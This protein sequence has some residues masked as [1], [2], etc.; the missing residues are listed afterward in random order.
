MQRM[1]TQPRASTPFVPPVSFHAQHSPIGAFLSFT[2]GLVGKRGGLAAQLGRPADQDIFVGIH[3]P[4]DPDVPLVCFPF[5]EGATDDPQRNFVAGPAPTSPVDRPDVVSFAAGQY[6]RDYRYA[7]D[8]FTAGD[9][10]W[11]IYTPFDPIPD[12]ETADP[13]HLAQVLLPAVRMELTLD[14]RR[15]LAARTIFFALRFQQTGLRPITAGLGPGR[16]GFAVRRE[17][18]F[19]AQALGPD[20]EPLQDALRPF[21]R[22]TVIDALTDRDN[23]VHRLGN[24]AGVALTVPAGTV[25][26][27]QLAVAAHLT[28]NVT[29]GIEG[30]YY[31]TRFYPT[32]ESVLA[33]ALSPDDFAAAVE[34]ARWLDDH[35]DTA[36]I[37][38]RRK[39]LLAHAVRSYHGSTQL[40]DVGGAPFW[41]VNEGE[42]CMMNTLDLSVD[43]MFWELRHNPWVVRNLLDHFAHHYSYT[44]TVGA[45]GEPKTRPGGLAFTHD[46][47]VH[48][49]FSPR[50]TSSYELTQLDAKCF[51]HMTAEE[52]CNWVLLAATY[53]AHTRDTNWAA[54]NLHLIEATGESLLNRCGP[55]GIIAFDS[56]R[57]GPDGSEITTYDSLDHS[58]A[59]TRNNLYIAVKTWA[60]FLGLRLL[61]QAAHHTADHA[62]TSDLEPARSSPDLAH[63]AFLRY[64]HAAAETVRRQ[65]RPD[66]LIPAVFEPDNPGHRSRI[67][68]AAE[69]LIYPLIWN[70]PRLGPDGHF[71]SLYDTLRRH[72]LACLN[73][74]EGLNRFPDGG[75]RLSSTSDNTW[76]SK[77]FIFQAVAERLGWLSPADADPD[78]DAHIRWLTTGN[79]AYWAFSD[80]IIR[81]VA[82]GSK[83]YPRGVTA[84]LWLTPGM[85]SR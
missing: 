18:G 52:L 62:T 49:Q 76:L 37:S 41:V 29:T 80:Q 30:S 28:G 64:A 65:A 9:L 8:T 46:M 21:C 78:D 44:D 20:E 72:T 19:A 79:S 36:P 45:P 43:H 27:M 42:Y 33:A 5:F 81:G 40:L 74:P 13:R 12:P 59:Q 31:Y 53:V 85:P 16:C 84:V 55:G 69:A 67:L 34:L 3:D 51:S 25:R 23:P 54:R 35:L 39:W 63:D 22:W 24:T 50:G 1:T 38:A 75:I 15:N 66:G 14:N 61:L 56:S 7:T 60:T 48:N 77:I 70:D 47:G 57:C 32:L 68:P 10:R 2:C 71:A 82:Q 4:A 73:H 58:L 26:T 83:Y 11:T 17:L 6:Q